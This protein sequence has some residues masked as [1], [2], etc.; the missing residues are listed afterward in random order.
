MDGM[1]DLFLLGMTMVIIGVPLQ[2]RIEFWQ[3]VKQ[4][5]MFL[6]TKYQKK[7]LSTD[8][9]LLKQMDNLEMI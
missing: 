9:K 2:V 8:M 7:L 3:H 6:F 1:G 4:E 5:L